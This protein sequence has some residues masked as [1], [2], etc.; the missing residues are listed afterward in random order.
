MNPLSPLTYHRRHKGSA[1]LL[2]TLITLA[3]LALYVMVSVLD[4]IPMRAHSHYLTRLSRVY[5]ITGSSLEPGI[6][7]QIQA[8]PGVAR[9]VPDNG[10]SIA[11]PSLIGTDNS[12]LL[13][14]SQDDAQ[15]LMDHCGVR[16][17]AGRM[18]EAR[19][20][21][22]VLSEEV[23]RALRLQIGDQ[24]DR[25]MDERYYGN[26]PAPM[27]LVGILERDPSATLPSTELGTGRTGPSAG[28]G[29]SVR[30]GLAS[31]EYL[32]GHELYAPRTIGLL[33]VAQ[34]G[35]KTTV[36]EFLETT[37]RSTRTEVE[38]YGEISELVEMGLRGLHLIFGVVNCLVAVVVALVVGVINRIALTRRL[39]EFGLL[40]AVGYHKKRLI[41][42]LTL[43]TAAVAGVGWTAG[44]A[45]SWLVLAWLRDGL[46]YS[47][48]MELDLANLAP[49]WFT[50]PIPLVVVA[51]ATLSARRTFARFDAISIIERGKLGMET[52]ARRRAAKRSSTKPLSSRTFYLR[53][54]RRGALLVASMAL[55]ILGVA[56]PA[57]LISV[58]TDAFEPSLEYLRYVSEVSPG[59]GNA[60]D[61][62]VTAQ[63]RGH[64]AV[65]RVIPAIPLGLTAL[66]PPGSG[67]GVSIYGVGEDG[68]PILMD[69]FGMHLVEGRLP[70][71][72]SNE[73]ALSQAVARNRGLRVGDTVGRSVEAGDE[74]DPLISDDIPTEMV[75]V[76]LLSVDDLWLGFAPF[77]YLESHELASSRPVHLLVI[78]AEGRKRELDTWLEESV[79]SVQTDVDTYEASRLEARRAAQSILLLFAAVES[80]IAVVAAVA[81]AVLNHIFFSQRR[82]EFGVLHAVGRSRPWLVLRTVRETGSVITVAW[83]IGAAMCVIGLVCAQAAIYAPRGL[84]LNFTNPAP[85]LFTLPIPLAVIAVGAG[86]IARTLRKLDPVA[87]IERR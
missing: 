14:V 75:V 11:T 4:S 46:Y 29:P 35:R 32:D 20:N 36:D 79:A 34:A 6:A 25:S 2:L 40:N 9:V 74:V 27:V 18:F 42:R 47:K 38:T 51:F 54:R 63:I 22:I 49:F 69:L 64:P 68:L 57:F 26:V 30:V 28:P 16:L 85:W 56:F 31:Y 66:V 45:F 70:L 33:V 10:L 13:G 5:P 48:G 80:I 87:V 1:L 67:T 60:L 81:L 41:S 84:S 65:A 8:H 58:V 59:T 78:P 61:P 50:L 77:E 72:R 21:E 24:I 3:T 71:A 62:G 39:A 23:A 82:D 73:I 12:R 7:S 53:H 37:I 83:L 15:Y 19:T 17:K 43:E 52:H 86:T 44:L 55:M 76:G